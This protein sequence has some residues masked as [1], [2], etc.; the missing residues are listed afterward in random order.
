M[1]IIIHGRRTPEPRPVFSGYYIINPI[2]SGSNK[3]P[4]N[5]FA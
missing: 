1:A 5:Q 4:Q 3:K 2:L